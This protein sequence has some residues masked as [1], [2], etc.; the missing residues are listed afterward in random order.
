M[1]RFDVARYIVYILYTYSYHI[2]CHG[3]LPD[4]FLARV[5]LGSSCNFIAYCCSLLLTPTKTWYYNEARYRL[6][7]TF[8]NCL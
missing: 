6:R 5:L 1:R 8:L 2:N 4:A 7:Y 3:T